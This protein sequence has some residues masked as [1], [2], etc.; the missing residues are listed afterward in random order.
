MVIPPPVHTGDHVGARFATD[1]AFLAAAAGFARA[2][3]DR[4]RSSGPVGAREVL[5]ARTA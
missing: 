5:P 4:R 1:D 2:G 3:R